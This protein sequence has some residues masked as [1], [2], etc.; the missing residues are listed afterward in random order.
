MQQAS[1][2]RI[3]VVN[4]PLWMLEICKMIKQYLPEDVSIDLP[5]DEGW[6]SPI[7]FMSWFSS[8]ANTSYY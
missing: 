5:S 7:W 2:R 3:I 6:L 8:S 1:G 4:R